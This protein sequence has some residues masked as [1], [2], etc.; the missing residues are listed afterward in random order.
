MLKKEINGEWILEAIKSKLKEEGLELVDYI[1]EQGPVSDAKV[2]MEVEV[3]KPKPWDGQPIFRSPDPQPWGPSDLHVPRHVLRC[4]VAEKFK[5][6]K[7][8]MAGG[9]AYTQDKPSGLRST[10]AAEQ[11]ENY[12]AV[13]EM[14]QPEEFRVGLTS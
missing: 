7:E 2:I 11:G 13:E 8:L 9:R 6:A 3:K 5:G 14:E 1:D 10:F 4:S 12:A